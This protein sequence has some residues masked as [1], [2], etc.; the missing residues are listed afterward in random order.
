MTEIIAISKFVRVSPRKVRLLAEVVKSFSPAEALVRLGFLKKAGAKELAQTLKSALAN[1]ENN[2]KIAKESL[3]IKKIEIGGGP[4]LKRFRA[5]AR[6]AA[7]QYKR[8]TSHIKI[9]LEEVY[10][11][12]KGVGRGTKNQS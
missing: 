9:I 8:R 10:L 5:V 2:L 4:F 6:G 12:G 3:K 1:A 7:H 11:E